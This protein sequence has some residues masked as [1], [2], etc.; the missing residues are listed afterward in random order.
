MTSKKNSCNYFN[1]IF[2]PAISAPLCSEYDE[3]KVEDYDDDNYF[4]LR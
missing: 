2:I 4:I 3:E 1:T